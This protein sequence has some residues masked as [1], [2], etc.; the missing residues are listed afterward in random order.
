[1]KMPFKKSIYRDVFE[2][3]RSL[4]IGFFLLSVALTCL[5][6]SIAERDIYPPYHARL[7][8]W[9]MVLLAVSFAFFQEL[10]VHAYH[11]K[12]RRLLPS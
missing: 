8:I 2:R 4:R 11:R 3:T 10:R 12:K 9:L 6:N 5:G 7:P 1:M